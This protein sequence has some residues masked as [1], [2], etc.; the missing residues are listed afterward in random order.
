MTTARLNLRDRMAFSLIMTGTPTAPIKEYAKT[1]KDLTYGC[2]FRRAM[3]DHLICT[4]ILNLI[5]FKE[6]SD[7]H[8]GIISMIDRE[9]SICQNEPFRTK[10]LICSRG[11]DE[12]HAVAEEIRKAR[13]NWHIVCI[14]STK[15][16]DN[17]NIVEEYTSE[18][19]GQSIK[20]NKKVFEVLDDMDN[21]VYEPFNGDNEP[22]IVFQVDMIGEGISIKSFNS[23]FITSVMDIK[24]LQNLG[25][26]LRNVILEDKNMDKID[27]G[28]ASV[29]CAY[30]N[31]ADL[32]KM[33][34]NLNYAELTDDCFTFGSKI[35]VSN[36]SA[37]EA[38]P[39]AMGEKADFHWEA[40]EQVDIDVIYKCGVR[41][42]ANILTSMLSDEKQDEITAF[43]TANADALKKLD[44]SKLSNKYLTKLE[45]KGTSSKPAKKTGASNK[46]ASSKE[47]KEKK[48][49]RS[50]SI[51]VIA[52][53]QKAYFTKLDVSGYND[54]RIYYDTERD[55][56]RSIL[57]D[58]G[59]T[60][61]I[62]NFFDNLF[63]ECNL[64]R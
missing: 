44:L 7:M 16:V 52:D 26:V 36:S 47:T 1:H 59:L 61:D 29:Y 33:M 19:D 23:V 45:K 6:Q 28:H 40:L 49:T 53:I 15:K 37:P 14:H 39:N 51:G 34:M 25:R 18:I 4:P 12:M 50:S 55:F 32:T 38:D 2:N 10:S 3:A 43:L 27:N 20:N 54:L 64:Y 57:E 35:D 22:I 8:S 30:T 21:N 46:K 17:N 58:F 41:C 62:L 60:G 11:I 56:N 13:P 24:M 31:Q 48:D 63:F 42:H 9:Q 5:K